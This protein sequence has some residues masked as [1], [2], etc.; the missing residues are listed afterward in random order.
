MTRLVFDSLKV[1]QHSVAILDLIP[2]THAWIKDCK[3]KFV[4][5]NNLFLK[6]FGIRSVQALQGKDDY[7]FSPAQM[8]QK[9]R[10]DDDQVLAGGEII[11]RLEMIL[12]EEEGAAWFLTSK[13][14]IYNSRDRILGSMGISRHLQ[15]EQRKAVPYQELREPIDYIARHFASDVSVTELAQACNLSVSALERRFKK[16]L[17]KTPRQYINEVRLEHARELLLETEKPIGTIALETGFSD[18]SHF[19]RTFKRQFGSSP[20]G[21]RRS[22][23]H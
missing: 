21:L 1:A 16:H 2:D 9:Y 15:P 12:G 8:A 14:P 7:D 22:D 23:M 10:R 18:H 19:T 17:Q 6:R 13:W 5:A 4:F 20:Q 3:G 11:D